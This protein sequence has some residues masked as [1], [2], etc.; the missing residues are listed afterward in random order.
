[1]HQVQWYVKQYF[2][3]IKYQQ[4]KKET[5]EPNQTSITTLKPTVISRKQ[6]FHS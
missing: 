2:L 1:M 4:F 6:S 5:Q 3:E